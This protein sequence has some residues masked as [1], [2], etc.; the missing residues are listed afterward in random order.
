MEVGTL[1]YCWLIWLVGGH[2]LGS[3]GDVGAY[4]GIYL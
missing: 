4:L 3:F 1:G 2:D